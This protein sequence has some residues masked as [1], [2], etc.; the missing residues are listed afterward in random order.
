MQHRQRSI[1]NVLYAGRDVFVD[2]DRPFHGA[3]GSARGRSTVSFYASRRRGRSDCSSMTWYAALVENY[4]FDETD[5]THTLHLLLQPRKMRDSFLDYNSSM[6]CIS[7]PIRGH[8]A[9]AGRRRKLFKIID[10]AGL[11]HPQHHSPD[12]KN[13]PAGTLQSNAREICNK[14]AVILHWARRRDRQAGGAHRTGYA[15]LPKIRR[16]RVCPSFFSLRSRTTSEVVVRK[17][18]GLYFQQSCS[19][20]NDNP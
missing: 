2:Y 1:R 16:R 14:G 8:A 12:V 19:K 4:L 17:A 20:S 5:C 6:T 18:L 7:T 10:S 3:I 11:R 13:Q 9:T 15:S